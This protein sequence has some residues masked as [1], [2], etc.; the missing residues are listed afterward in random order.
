MPPLDA[1]GDGDEAQDEGEDGEEEVEEKEEELASTCTTVRDEVEVELL[2]SLL[3]RLTPAIR[4]KQKSSYTLLPGG[5][6]VAL[7]GAFPLALVGSCCCV[8]VSGGGGGGGGSLGRALPPWP[9]ASSSEEMEPI[10]DSDDDD[11][12]DEVVKE[13]VSSSN[14][15]R[16]SVRRGRTRK[17]IVSLNWSSRAVVPLAG[18]PPYP[19]VLAVGDDRSLKLLR[20]GP[21]LRWNTV[22]TALGLLAATGHGTSHVSRVETHLPGPSG[23]S[24]IIIMGE[25]PGPGI[26]CT[27]FRPPV[28]DWV[29]SG[30]LELAIT[31]NG[32]GRWRALIVPCLPKVLVPS[33]D[34]LP[35]AE[36]PGPPAPASFS[37]VTIED[38]G[39]PAGIEDGRF[40]M[41]FIALC[42][43][44]G[45][46]ASAVPDGAVEGSD[47][48]SSVSLVASSCRC[49]ERGGR[50]G[51]PAD[52]ELG[53]SVACA[54]STG[55]STGSYTN[56]STSSY[57]GAPDTLVPE[58]SNS[59]ILW[60]LI[61]AILFAGFGLYRLAY[62]V[63]RMFSYFCECRSN[64]SPSGAN[65]LSMLLPPTVPPPEPPPIPLSEIRS[66][67][68]TS[69][70]R[71]DLRFWAVLVG[72][73]SSR[74]V[75]RSGSP[76]QQSWNDSSLR[77]PTRE[78][79]LLSD[80]DGDLAADERFPPAVLPL[81]PRD[82]LVLFA[83]PRSFSFRLLL[84]DFGPPAPLSAGCVSLD[85]RIKSY[86]SG[87]PF[88]RMVGR[89]FLPYV[90]A[91]LTVP[92]LVRIGAGAR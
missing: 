29:A 48:L 92:A 86:G 9:T 38:G 18:C 31:G 78:P 64:S 24:P 47:R 51:V 40:R 10:D 27:F 61:A 69:Q 37:T 83:R 88:P 17:A 45:D 46:P 81:R 2:R 14:A 42:V 53:S 63:S 15:V 22:A 43:T 21:A 70:R 3:E 66:Y 85:R 60:P 87:F 44:P 19:F 11:D 76:T 82:G 68:L 91:S 35:L 50:S 28:V 75:S 74:S 32:V 13:A 65:S 33:S 41:D 34:A 12:E 1:I 73:S 25:W 56:S 67:G 52:G 6:G 59:L 71:M 36:V 4:P 30:S 58:S 79:F 89:D 49:F 90:D 54:S 84:T 57:T 62:S 77:P 80:G 26:H 23:P 72:P 16:E 20:T 7:A 39:G 8:V 5:G 55:T